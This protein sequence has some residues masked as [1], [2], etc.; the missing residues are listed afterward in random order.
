VIACD[1]S[2]GGDACV[3]YHMDNMK[4]TDK[5]T[6]YEKDTMKIAGELGIM[7]QK[8]QTNDIIV[9]KIGV[10]KGVFDRLNELGFNAIGFNSAENATNNDRFYNRKAEAW[11]LV[12]EAIRDKRIPYPED[13]ELR[14]QLTAVQYM[15]VDS[16][17]KIQL[18]PKSKTKQRLGRSPDEA[19]AYIMGIYASLKY[20]LT[21]RR[22]FEEAYL[23]DRV[24]YGEPARR[25]EQVGVY[26]GY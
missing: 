21:T 13:E 7:A 18:E 9:D 22:Q 26:K 20:E 23:V 15:V 14:R 10:G 6:L 2:E 4:I 5:R 1:P 16:N 17:G 24:G 12:M 8:T 3:I 11:W 25:T 19:D